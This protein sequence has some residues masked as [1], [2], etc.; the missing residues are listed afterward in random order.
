MESENYKYNSRELHFETYMEHQTLLLDYICERAK[1]LIQRRGV[2]L[3]LSNVYAE[4]WKQLS[5]SRKTSG[6]FDT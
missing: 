2:N 4:F 5:I 3:I 6:G 1:R